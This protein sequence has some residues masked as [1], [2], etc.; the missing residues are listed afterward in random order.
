LRQPP[1]EFWR[2]TPRRLY[3]LQKRAAKE[4]ERSFEPF[5]HALA[6]IA[7]MRGAKGVRPADFMP[8]FEQPKSDGPGLDVYESFMRAAVK[9]GT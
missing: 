1:D 8:R 6:H 7:G 3:A 9:N 5:A 2:S 4:Y